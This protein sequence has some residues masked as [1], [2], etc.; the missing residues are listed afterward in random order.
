MPV[1]FSECKVTLT[2]S[3]ALL[4]GSTDVQEMYKMD[5]AMLVSILMA[6]GICRIFACAME[7]RCLALLEPKRP[8]YA[9]FKSLSIRL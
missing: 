3:C 5:L 7:L 1:H 2:F 9:S 4:H 8:Q 6:R